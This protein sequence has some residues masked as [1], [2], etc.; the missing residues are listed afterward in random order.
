VEPPKGQN[1]SFGSEIESIIGAFRDED[2]D[3]T[4]AN[5]NYKMS[6][7]ESVGRSTYVRDHSPLQE[8]NQ[9]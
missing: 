9:G 7:I 1:D 4:L 8:E 3:K 2:D 6:Q 5:L